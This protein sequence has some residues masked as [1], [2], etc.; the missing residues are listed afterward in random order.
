MPT[1]PP[2]LPEEPLWQDSITQLETLDLHKVND[3]AKQL[4]DRTV[5]LK[6]NIE[7]F[8]KLIADS[9]LIYRNPQEGYVLTMTAFL[10]NIGLKEA[11]K[12]SVGQGLK[13]IPDM[14]CFKSTKRDTGIQYLPGG[15]IIQWGIWQLPS[16]GKFNAETVGGSTWYTHYTKHPYPIK[17][18]HVA[19]V[20]FVELAGSTFEAQ[21]R[22]F[23]TFVRSNMSAGSDGKAGSGTHACVSVTSRVLGYT[24]I[25][26]WLA[27]GY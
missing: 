18:P 3:Q 27:I 22:E 12:R 15:I 7:E 19:L 23:N 5:Y 2:I 21:G 10:E 20:N 9:K 17:F 14:E 25:V 16:V 11:G 13:Q 8:K 6:K 1:M 26:H 4:A 24:P